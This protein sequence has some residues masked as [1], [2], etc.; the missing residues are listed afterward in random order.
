MQGISSKTFNFAGTENN[1]KFNSIEHNKDFDLNMYEAFYRNLDPQIGRFW[2]IDPKPCDSM[3][4]YSFA[5]NNPIR[6]SDPLGDTAILGINNSAALGLG[7][8][9]LI[10]Q[11][12]NQNWFVYSMGAAPTEKGGDLVSGRTGAGEVTI[13]AV[14]PEN[15]KGLP[16]GQLTSGQI[17]DFLAGNK[18]GDTKVSEPIVIATT[19]KQD[20]T[21]AANANQSKADYASGK[22]KYNLWTNNSTNATMKVLNN[23][24]GLNLTPVFTLPKVNHEQVSETIMLR[25]MNPAQRK[26]YQDKWEKKVRDEIRRAHGSKI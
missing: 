20:E 21:I 6:Y 16:E 11:D 25:N 22:E 13:T 17:T 15:F 10:Y 4:L 8:E 2:Q 12:K 14:T 3:S 26:E 18:L 23:N 9:I 7:H 1:K 24:T 19:Q 5:Y